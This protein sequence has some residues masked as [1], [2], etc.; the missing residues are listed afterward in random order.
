MVIAANLPDV[1]PLW[2]LAQLIALAILVY[3]FLRWRPGFLR[4]RTIGQTVGGVL[5]AREEQIRSQLE[6]AQ[7]SREEAARIHEESQRE[8]A[9]AQQEAETI[10]SRAAETSQAI[11]KDI[12]ARAQE[13]YDRIVGQARMQMDY[14]RERAALALR[15]EAAD[16]VVEAA[17]QIVERH[18]DPQTDRRIIG[19]S[20][21]DMR[22]IR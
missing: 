5:D 19:E 17:R 2:F 16:I 22:E 18:L 7:R 14:E 3:L 9:Q 6:A 15:R 10:V 13:E 4:G 12:Q 8:R 20:L 1:Y 11:Q 21:E